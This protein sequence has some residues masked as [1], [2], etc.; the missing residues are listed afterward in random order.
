MKQKSLLGLL[1]LSCVSCLAKRPIQRD[2]SYPT[3]TP[4]LK[5][6]VSAKG[7]FLAQATRPKIDAKKLRVYRASAAPMQFS[8]VWVAYLN[9]AADGDADLVQWEACPSYRSSVTQSEANL[10]CYSGQTTDNQLIFG[11]LSTLTYDI[12]LKACVYQ[13]RAEGGNLCGQETRL[14]FTK[15]ADT[16]RVRAQEVAQLFAVHAELMAYGALLYQ[17]LD[18]FTVET[19]RCLSEQKKVQEE[20][21]D[22]RKILRQEIKI[23]LEN[24]RSMGP[25][26]LGDALAAVPRGSADELAKIVDAGQ[27]NTGGD[28]TYKPIG[29]NLTEAASSLGKQVRGF[30]RYPGGIKPALTPTANFRQALLG[31]SGFATTSN[32]AGLTAA[33]TQATGCEKLPASTFDKLSSAQKLDLA[34]CQVLLESPDMD[35]TQATQTALYLVVQASL[36]RNISPPDGQDPAKVCLSYLFINAEKNAIMKQV[37]ALWERYNQLEEKLNL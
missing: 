35:P 30:Y 29:M 7:F 8:G 26:L 33:D 32:L 34:L 24:I 4:G 17:L 13:S 10:S 6:A 37:Y 28:S 12:T 11:Q 15:P 23:Q 36:V 3:P 31:S 25:I 27:R 1:F 21:V 14:S 20:F 2:I 5:E 9:F 22:E 16:N 19:Q 18:K